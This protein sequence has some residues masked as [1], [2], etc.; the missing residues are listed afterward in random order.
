MPGPPEPPAGPSGRAVAALGLAVASRPDLWW[1]AFGVLRRL[2]APGWWR[3]R[4]PLPLPSGRLWAFRMVTAYGRPDRVPDRAD[5]IS[6]LE[7]CRST[8]GAAR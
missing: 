6:Y 2:A 3:S 1:T 8:A 5:V 4:P 7:W